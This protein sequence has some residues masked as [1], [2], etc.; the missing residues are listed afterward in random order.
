MKTKEEII[1]F[2]AHHRPWFPKE[3]LKTL[4]LEA[5]VLIKANIELEL[6]LRSIKKTGNENKD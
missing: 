6:G 3:E 2:I 5:I 4:P 1:D